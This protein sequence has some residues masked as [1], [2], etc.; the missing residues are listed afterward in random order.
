MSRARR[1]LLAA[2]LPA[3]VVGGLLAAATPASAN[4]AVTQVSSDPFTDAQAQHRTEVEPDTFAF[5]STIVSAF[6]VGRVSG[7]GSSDVGFAT[8]TDGG[9]TW[10]Q[11]FLPGTT[12]NTGGPCGQISDAAVAFDA[13]HNVWL[14][15][16]L[17]VNC[18]GNP[19]FTSRSTDGGKTFGNPGTT[20]TGSLDKNWIVCDN[21]ATSPFFGNCYTEYDITSSGDALRM[22]TSTDGG[23]TWGP[24]RATGDNATGLGGQPI[25]RP[26][27]TVL[28][29]YLSLNNQIRSFRS[30]DG[31]AS[32]RSTVLVSG[33]S[34]HDAA[35]GLREEALPSA[36]IDSA[37]T[38]YVAWSDCRFRSGCPRNDIVLAKSTSETTWAT[39]TRVPI[40]ATTSSVDHFV[41][42]L[43]IDPSTSG[44]TARIGLTY[45]FY[46]NSACTAATCQLDAGFISSVNGGT[47]WSTATQVAGPMTLSWIPNTSQ[48]RMFGDYISTS[49]RSGGNAFPIVPIASAPAGSTFAMG[50]FAPTGGLAIT[51]GAARASNTPAAQAPAARQLSSLTTAY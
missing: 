38:A 33:I 13:K 27:G 34:H 50:M 8:S 44:G 10:T 30:V 20:A 48:G 11:G 28:V 25:V 17:G 12:A 31:G 5:G 2:L 37:G 41:P 51:G 29:P 1:T 49:V 39:P 26:N 23:L 15:S 42:G 19:V 36:E 24:A 22:K 3:V 14:I 40:D 16:S 43:G 45:Y 47:S 35:G 9:A 6:Q 32:W 4:V 18:P 7:G 46:P 21:T